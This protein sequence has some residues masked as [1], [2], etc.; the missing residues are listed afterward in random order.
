MTSGFLAFVRLDLDIILEIA[1]ERLLRMICWSNALAT[2]PSTANVTFY[3]CA[4]QVLHLSRRSYLSLDT[5]L[6][7]HRDDNV[8]A[9][10]PLSLLIRVFVFLS[11]L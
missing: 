11:Y 10:T 3:L 4:Y 8:I 1:T 7:N 2:E 9:F 6:E 5:I